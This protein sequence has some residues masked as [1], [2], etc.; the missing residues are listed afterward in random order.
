VAEI[1]KPLREDVV[2]EVWRKQWPNHCPVRLTDGDG[3]SVGACWHYLRD[4]QCPVHGQ[5]YPSRYG[6]ISELFGKDDGNVDEVFAG[7]AEHA[8]QLGVKIE[9][10]GGGPTDPLA[11]RIR[12]SLKKAGGKTGP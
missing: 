2:G 4:G 12:A 6:S 11:E 10:E 1:P 9:V 8:K 5:I 7:V 3:H